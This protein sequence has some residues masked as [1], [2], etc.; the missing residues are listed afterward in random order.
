MA[1]ISIKSLVETAKARG[2]HVNEFAGNYVE[3]FAPD[4]D[5]PEAVLYNGCVYSSA[6][7]ILSDRP[8]GYGY[9]GFFHGPWH[10]GMVQSNSIKRFL[11]HPA[12]Q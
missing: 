1:L 4:H 7:F 6:D 2:F 9:N 5:G 3:L 12:M 8:S 11:N 10:T